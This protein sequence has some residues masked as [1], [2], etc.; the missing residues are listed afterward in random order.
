MRPVPHSAVLPIPKTPT[1]ITLS[2]SESSDEN[3]RQANKNMDCDPTFAEAFSSNEQY[4]LTQGDMYVI[5]RNLNLSKKQ[6]EIL[7][8]KLKGWNLLC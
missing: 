1:N 8:S 4:L 2:D 3:V 7:G 5:I 6:A